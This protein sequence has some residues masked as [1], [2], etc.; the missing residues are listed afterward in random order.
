MASQ[1][2]VAR[3][4]HHKSTGIVLQISLRMKLLRYL[5][6]AQNGLEM[7]RE[8]NQ[9]VRETTLVCCPN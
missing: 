6:K 4:E 7:D 3:V 9:K 1:R 5:E 2:G 8:S